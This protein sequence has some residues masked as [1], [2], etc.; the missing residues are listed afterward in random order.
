MELEPSNK[1]KEN[2]NGF[3][4]GLSSGKLGSNPVIQ[5]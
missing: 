4:V 3:L 2:R 5:E 1:N